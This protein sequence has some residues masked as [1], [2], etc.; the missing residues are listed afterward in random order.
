VSL[1]KA[2]PGFFA[3]LGLHIVRGAEFESRDLRSDPDSGARLPVVINQSAARNLFG[4]S[5]PMGRVIRQGDKVFQVVGVAR[6]EKSAVFQ[7]EPVPAVFLP[8]TMQDLQ[9]GRM[10]VVRLR[11]GVGFAA[12]RGEMKAIDSRLTLVNVQTMDEYLAQFSQALEYITAIYGTAGMF[13]LILACVGLAG[14]T[15]QAVVRRR[16]EIGIRMALGARR[17]QVLRLVM[18]EG[19]AMVLVGS[20]MGIAGAGAVVRVFLWATASIGPVNPG[21]LEPQQVVG[22]PLLL[23]AVAAIACYLPARR[24]ATIDPVAALRDE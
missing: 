18:K 11:Q 9:R 23:I 24:S 13:A 22:P 15:A 14:V 17:R 7:R 19:A 8:L 5:D 4:D 6:Y 16:R 3:A 12:I 10:V 1:Q 21:V 2:G 20:V